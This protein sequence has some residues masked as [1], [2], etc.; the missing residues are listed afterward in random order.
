MPTLFLFSNILVWPESVCLSSAGNLFRVISK[1]AEGQRAAIFEIGSD[2]R[3]AE[4]KQ[5]VYGVAKVARFI[6][7]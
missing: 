5:E 7:I 3:V 6:D 2:F 4:G 1:F